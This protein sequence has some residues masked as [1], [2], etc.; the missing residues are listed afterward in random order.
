[1]ENTKFIGTINGK[2]YD[3][4]MDFYNAYLEASKNNALKNVQY[5]YNYEAQDENPNQLELFKS[6]EAIKK[7]DLDCYLDNLWCDIS[8]AKNKKDKDKFV[9]DAVKKISDYFASIENDVELANAERNTIINIMKDYADMNDDLQSQINDLEESLDD[10]CAILEIINKVLY[11]HNKL[12]P[13]CSCDKKDYDNSGC[14][15]SECTNKE[16]KTLNSDLF[17]ELD[18]AFKEFTNAW[19]DCGLFKDTI[20]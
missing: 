7:M 5:S 18:A 12:E 16:Q 10:N 14:C 1:M 15:T 4:A 8:S 19:K 3:N 9:N 20:L 11:N 2:T 17:K 6:K 13:K